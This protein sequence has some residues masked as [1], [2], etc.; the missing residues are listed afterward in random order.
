MKC[1]KCGY[2]GFDTGPRCKNCSYE[3]ALMDHDE[4]TV[5]LSDLEVLPDGAGTR[6]VGDVG[7]AWLKTIDAGAP[8]RVVFHSVDEGLLDSFAKRVPGLEQAQ[9]VFDATDLDRL[10]RDAEGGPVPL[11]APVAAPVTPSLVLPATV[12]P[13]STAGAAV[14]DESL[15]NS[16][17]LDDMPLVQLHEPRPPV[18]VR[19]TPMSPKLRAVTRTLPVEPAFDFV[20]E[21]GTVG[22]DEADVPDERLSTGESVEQMGWEPSG[23]G[24]RLAALVLDGLL[25]GGIDG[26]VLYLTLRFVGLTIADVRVLPLWPLVLFFVLL[27][28]T[29]VAAF[30]AL[31]GQTI[32]K[33]AMR[34]RVVADDNMSL[35]GRAAVWRTLA[36]SLS[37][38]TAGI[39]Y[40]PALVGR[41]R[42]ALHDRI[43]G[44][45]VVAL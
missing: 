42:R 24:R 41:D 29:Y 6:T 21:S 33:M 10:L 18:A 15:R 35:S 17:A 34:I 16:P 43:A 37:I 1:P 3:F 26:G 44:S 28:A 11:K 40:L 39:T 8:A 38:A 23:V 30:T 7:A 4:S 13:L 27:Q 5:E 45:R 9:S 36:T 22:L 20:S 19:K 32:G 14:P 2:L 25:W 31:G 12:A